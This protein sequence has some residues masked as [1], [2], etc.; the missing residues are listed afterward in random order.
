MWL[1][2]I[3]VFGRN[4]LFYVAVL[5]ILLKPA[6][7]FMSSVGTLVFRCVL[8][9][10]LLEVLFL[11]LMCLNMGILAFPML[12]HGFGWEVWFP[13]EITRYLV[14]I[15]LWCQVKALNEMIQWL[16]NDVLWQWDDISVFIAVFFLYAS[17][18]LLPSFYFCSR[19]V[20]F[21]LHRLWIK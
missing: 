14:K 21:I 9:P 20:N 3:C 4:G 17:H 19:L 1:K 13:R 2:T 8:W 16:C 6:Y 18:M 11:N 7:W 10:A 15:C 12:S 5:C